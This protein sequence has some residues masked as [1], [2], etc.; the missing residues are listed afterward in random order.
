MDTQTTCYVENPQRAVRSSSHPEHTTK[1][2]THSWALCHNCICSDPLDREARLMELNQAF[3]RLI[4][5][6][7]RSIDKSME[8]DRFPRRT[9]H[10]QPQDDC[11]G[12]TLLL[13]GRLLNSPSQSVSANT[14]GFSSAFSWALAQPESPHRRRGAVL[15]SPLLLYFPRNRNVGVSCLLPPSPCPPLKASRPVTV[16][17]L[18]HRDRGPTR[19]R[20]VFLLSGFPGVVDPALLNKLGLAG[21]T[22]TTR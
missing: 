9:L 4:G 20:A 6:P 7:A 19:P 13:S 14:A 12:K 1:S 21:A 11:F 15:S 2:I 18:P 8:L 10:G 22:H 16:C 5:H 17:V 3:R